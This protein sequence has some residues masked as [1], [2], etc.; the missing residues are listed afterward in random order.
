MVKV[1]ITFKYIIIHNN[2]VGYEKE[3]LQTQQDWQTL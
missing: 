1:T 2:Y 3:N